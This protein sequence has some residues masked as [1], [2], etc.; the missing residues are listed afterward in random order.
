VVRVLARIQALQALV[1][2]G[3]WG[4]RV[5]AGFLDHLGMGR[6]RGT[7]GAPV[8]LETNAERVIV[9]LSDLIFVQAVARA[10][11]SAGGNRRCTT[12]TAVGR[13]RAGGGGGLSER[14]KDEMLVNQFGVKREDAF[15]GEGHLEAGALEEP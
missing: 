2:Q 8:F 12:T 1:R 3:Q 6:A 14:R 15:E 5:L 7:F 11:R 4:S 9:T 13:T 10:S